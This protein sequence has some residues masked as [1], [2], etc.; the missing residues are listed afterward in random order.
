M[1]ENL[2]GFQLNSL[3]MKLWMKLDEAETPE[4]ADACCDTID[5]IEA[6][7]E[8]KVVA[9]AHVLRKLDIEI[10]VSEARQKA[11]QDEVDAVK[12]HTQALEN[13]RKRI[14]E[15]AGETMNVM[16]RTKLELDGVRM[17][18]RTYGG[19]SVNI[20]DADRIPEEYLIPQP[21]KV[22]KKA[23][24]AALKETGDVPG[25]ELVAPTPKFDFKF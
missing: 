9:Y 23:I 20:V 19:G 4:E 1:A 17:S 16:G 25:C 8:D 12:K 10:K 2:S 21:S 15:M 11:M 22:D 5:S 6:L 24:L 18:M 13:K 3:A 7:Q 14:Q